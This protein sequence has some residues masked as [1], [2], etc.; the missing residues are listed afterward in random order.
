MIINFEE[1]NDPSEFLCDLC[2][3]GSGAAGLS[4]TSEMLKT[5]INV[6][7]IESGGFE[8][9]APTQSLYDVEMSGLPH[10]GSMEGRF[11]IHGGSTTKWG[12]QA[13][14]LMPIDFEKREWIPYSGWP[15]KFTDLQP[16][17]I[18]ACEFLSVDKMNFDSDLFAYLKTSPPAFDLSSIWY[19]FSKWSPTPNIRE[20]LLSQ[21]KSSHS[22]TLL[23]HA[24]VTNI[25]LDEQLNN[26][27]KIEIR[28]L[29]GHH[30]FVKAKIFIVCVGGIETARLLLSSHHQLQN[31]IGNNH[32][33]VGRFFQDHPSAAIGWIKTCNFKNVQ[34]LFNVFH[35]GGLKY[36]VRC[37]AA[38]EWQYKKQTLNLS[39]GITFVTENS[40]FNELK[41][42]YRSIKK[43]HFS[44]P[45]LKKMLR[46]LEHPTEA[47]LPIFHYLF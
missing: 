9:E 40:L 32:D 8:H 25:I 39:T 1:M 5:N 4:I 20:T 11:R 2:I 33:L 31:G 28:S 12:G 37:T 17:Y 16:Y 46:I 34:Q 3:I 42:I 41:D 23:L 24:N 29:V 15:I 19:H 38:P 26:V 44:I 18:R 35:K 6:L 45:M 13:L 22:A 43:Y 30:A 10:P 21:I 7:L 14:P 47:I 27:C 36:S